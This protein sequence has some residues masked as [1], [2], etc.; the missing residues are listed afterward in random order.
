LKRNLGLR[1]VNRPSVGQPIRGSPNSDD[2][3]LLETRFGRTNIRLE[4]RGFGLPRAASRCK[5]QPR[6]DLMDQSISRQPSMLE[7]RGPFQRGCGD[8]G[9]EP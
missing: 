3:L 5:G 1:P 8:H 6:P 4:Q 7:A 2:A 9:V